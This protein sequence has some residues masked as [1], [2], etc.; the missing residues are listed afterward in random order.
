M[1]TIDEIVE[2][3]HE[4]HEVVYTIMVEVDGEVL[5]KYTSSI[6]A[7]DVACDSEHVDELVQKA[8][9]E[10]EEGRVEYEKEAEGERQMEEARLDDKDGCGV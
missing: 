9:I 8:A 2:Q 7:S 10:E 4:K 6:D 1:K 5:G 3:Y